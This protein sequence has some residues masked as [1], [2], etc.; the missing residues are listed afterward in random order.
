MKKPILSVQTG[1]WF[2]KLFGEAKVDEA[3]AFI[4]ECGFEAM[5]YNLDHNHTPTQINN[6]QRSVFLDQPMETILEYY[7]PVKEAIEKHGIGFVMAHAPFPQT[8]L[9]IRILMKM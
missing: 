5:D 7:R 4:K 3:F 9:N 1:N 2:D 6:G 8:L